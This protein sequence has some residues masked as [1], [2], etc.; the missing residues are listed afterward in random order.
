ML[1]YWD[2]ELG[3]SLLKFILDNIVSKGIFVAHLFDL[4][5]SMASTL[6]SEWNKLYIVKRLVKWKEILDLMMDTEGA[7]RKINMLDIYF[8]KWKTLKDW[9]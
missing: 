1:I 6:T 9:L 7:R 4:L 2:T 8:K 5:N 3:M